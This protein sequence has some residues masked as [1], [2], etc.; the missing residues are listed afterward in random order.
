MNVT[1]G[2][3]RCSVRSGL[4]NCGWRPSNADHTRFQLKTANGKAE[5]KL[6][7][8]SSGCQ[9]WALK[10]GK[11]EL[12][13]KHQLFHDQHIVQGPGKFV[14]D[15]AEN[16]LCRFDLP[17]EVI[18]AEGEFDL[19][20]RSTVTPLDLW[21]EVVTGIAWGRSPVSAATFPEEKIAGELEKR[22]WVTSVEA[23]IVRITVPLVRVFRQVTV[24]TREP[25]VTY[26]SCELVNLNGWCDTS[27]EAAMKFLTE[28]NNRLQLVRF[29]H[30]EDRFYAEV[31]LSVMRVPGVWLN[32]A[33]EAVRTAIA[34]TAKELVALRDSGLAELSLTEASVQHEGDKL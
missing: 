33:L 13:L 14:I 20:T 23:G 9:T 32:T 26:V 17:Q 25:G 4:E 6:V 15:G 18:S 22:G 30:R 29:A 8:L 19:G 7:H 3:V 5:L 31:N 24:E 28:A 27:C 1:T 11:L 2:E 21:C 34:L 12:P 16:I 10:T